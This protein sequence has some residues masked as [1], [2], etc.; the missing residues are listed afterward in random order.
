MEVLAP[1]L[2]IVLP[3]LDVDAGASAWMS[4]VDLPLDDLPTLELEPAPMESA[5]DETSIGNEQTRELFAAQAGAIRDQERTIVWRAPSRDES[6]VGPVVQEG[7]PET[8]ADD[9]DGAPVDGGAAP[10]VQGGL[11]RGLIL[12]KL[13]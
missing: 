3:R 5:S 11:D 2:N 13:T 9:G 6:A 8:L 10:F 4:L 1:S 7:E 12:H